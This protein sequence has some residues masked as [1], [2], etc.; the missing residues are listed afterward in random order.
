MISE[1]R[2]KRAGQT[3]G[4]RDWRGKATDGQRQR[5]VDSQDYAFDNF[6]NR[7]LTIEEDY[8]IEAK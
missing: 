8:L 5:P 7:G 3:I 1:G 6:V 4:R 2:Y